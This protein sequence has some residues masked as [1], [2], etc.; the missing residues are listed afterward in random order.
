MRT[1][2]DDADSDDE[3]DGKFYVHFAHHIL[4]CGCTPDYVFRP[5]R[6]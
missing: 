6:K 2:S 5:Q 4:G 3:D 1:D